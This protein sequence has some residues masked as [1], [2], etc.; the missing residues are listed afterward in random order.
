MKMEPAAE[1]AEASD[2][3]LA[4]DHCREVPAGLAGQGVCPAEIPG[5]ATATLS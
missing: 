5:R 4:S 2:P 3:H 1:G